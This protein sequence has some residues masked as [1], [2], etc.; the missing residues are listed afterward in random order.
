MEF[1]RSRV[2]S[3][4][5]ADELKVGDKVIVAMS[6][7][8]LRDEVEKGFNIVELEAVLPDHYIDRFSVH[9]IKKGDPELRQTALAYLVERKKNCTNCGEGKWDAEHKKILCDPVH[10]GN[11]N[12]V[13]RNQEVEVCEYWK[14]KT[15]KKAEPHYRPFK[16]TDELIKVWKE[17]SKQV[18]SDYSLTM[19][20]IWV[21]D[22][23]NDVGKAQH[24]IT[25]F[26]VTMLNEDNDGYDVGITVNCVDMTLEDLFEHFEFLDGSPC[27][28]EE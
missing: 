25:D 28:V 20:Y 6:V 11:G 17:K 12:V 13:F 16:D 3:S 14:P 10:C 26:N 24:L 27:G 22:K 21:Q 5:N 8:E 15:K 2:Y 18:H 19:P 4:V 23:D 9:V 1:D 7:Q